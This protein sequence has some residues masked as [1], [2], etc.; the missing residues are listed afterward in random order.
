RHH[1][2]PEVGQRH[3]RRERQAL[4]HLRRHRSEAF[5]CRAD[6]QDALVRVHRGKMDC[7]LH[8]KMLM[9]LLKS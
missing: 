1:P 6:R 5:D 2:E 7:Y 9:I 8:L 4:L 3:R